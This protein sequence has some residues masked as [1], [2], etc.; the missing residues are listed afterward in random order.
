MNMHIGLFEQVRVD[1]EILGARLHQGQGCLGALLHDVAKLSSQDE[2]V[3][4]GHSCGLD[5]QDIATNGRPSE[6]GRN[7]RQARPHRNYVFEFSRAKDRWEVR[8]VD[9]QTGNRTFRN[10][11]SNIPADSADL[12]LQIAHTCLA[13][14][15]ANDRTD[16]GLGYFALL[17]LKPR[18]LKLPFE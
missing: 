7:P 8:D 15:V 6:P 5:K 13:R 18:C 3:S 9:P 17:W 11:H 2:L 4:T 16:G 12:A 10:P 1:V 14:V